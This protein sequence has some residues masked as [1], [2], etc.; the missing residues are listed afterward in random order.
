MQI[1]SGEGAANPLFMATPKPLGA[2]GCIPHEKRSGV[3]MGVFIDEKLPELFKLYYGVD[4][5]RD[6]FGLAEKLQ[7]DVHSC[8]DLIL[9]LQKCLRSELGFVDEETLKLVC[10]YCLKAF[11]KKGEKRVAVLIKDSEKG[12]IVCKNCGTVVSS[13]EDGNIDADESLDDS[14]P[15]GEEWQPGNELNVGGGRGATI[16]SYNQS[17]DSFSADRA[18]Q[19]ILGKGAGNIEFEKLKT[20]EKN[21]PEAAKR[22]TDPCKPATYQILK[23][24][25]GETWVY[26]YRCYTKGTFAGLKFVAK[27]PLN[28]FELYGEKAFD[29]MKIRI[30]RVNNILN[31]ELP[32]QDALIILG[33]NLGKR[34]GLGPLGVKLHPQYAIF[35]DA[36]GTNIKTA[37]KNC[38]RYSYKVSNKVLV[39]TM[40]QL[41]VM[42]FKYENL[43]PFKGCRSELV[44]DENLSYLVSQ[45]DN[46]V[47]VLQQKGKSK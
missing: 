18:L 3:Q 17:N 45:I 34:Y 11:L 32:G 1:N 46:F 24:E 37:F 38:D 7:V 31:V 4:P 47:K 42:Q 21:Y 10:P 26:K 36:F 20:F 25:K 35:N 40:F 33:K 29:C 12:E 28:D 22:L 2:V 6:I 23:N 13:F 41:T 16:N 15:F 27:V 14:K 30:Q 19:T 5:E 8:V 9:E 43:E 44:F 39:E